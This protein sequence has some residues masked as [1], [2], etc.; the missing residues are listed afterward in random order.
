MNDSIR[1]SDLQPETS[2]LDALII[3]TMITAEVAPAIL[4]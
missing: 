3:A 4:A 2:P 1:K